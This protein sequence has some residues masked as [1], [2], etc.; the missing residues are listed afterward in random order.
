MRKIEIRFNAL[1]G[2]YK[3]ILIMPDGEETEASSCCEQSEADIVVDAI[4]R[5]ANAK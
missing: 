5:W 1:E 2:L 4:Q 3:V